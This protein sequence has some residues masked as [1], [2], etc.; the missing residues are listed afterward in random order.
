VL[1][2]V[3]GPTALTA[4]ESGESVDL[5]FSDVV[6][7]NRMRGGELARRAQDKR[8]GLKVLLT[9]GYTADSSAGA[10]P[11][12]F[13]LLRKPYRHVELARA[14]RAALDR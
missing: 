11:E 8:A 5:L 7:P 9:S 12:E 10:P 6:M 1:T 3:D 2:A 4:L 14:I 13:A